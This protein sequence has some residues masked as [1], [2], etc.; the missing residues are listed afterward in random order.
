MTIHEVIDVLWQSTSM[1]SMAILIV[2]SLRPVV[3]R[4]FG[5]QAAYFL[6]ALVLL[7]AVACLLP[8]P[9]RTMAIMHSVSLAIPHSAVDPVA[10]PTQIAAAAVTNIQASFDPDWLI[11]SAWVTGVLA[12][13]LFLIRQQCRYLRNLGVLSAAEKGIWR[14]QNANAS[15]A[16]VGALRPRIVLPGAFE[17]Q[18]SVGERELIVAHERIHLRHG[19]P[20]INA[21]SATLRC[22]CWFNPLVHFAASRLRFD[23]ELACDAAVIMR[24][25]EARRTY[26]DAMLKVQ[27]AGESRQE[28][29]LPVGCYWPSGHPLKE[30]IMMLKQPVPPRGRRLTGVVLALMLNA[31]GSYLAWAAQPPT[32]SGNRPDQQQMIEVANLQLTIDGE[33]VFNGANGGGIVFPA[34]WPGTLGDGGETDH[35]I[36]VEFLAHPLADGRIELSTTIASDKGP[37]MP[38][39]LLAK[40]PSAITI[41]GQPMHVASS[42]EQSGHDIQL[43]AIVSVHPSDY[44]CEELVG[45]AAANKVFALTVMEPSSQEWSATAEAIKGNTLFLSADQPLHFYKG[46]GPSHYDVKIAVAQDGP[47]TFEVKS[48]LHHAGAVDARSTYFVS[49]DEPSQIKFAD[50]AGASAFELNYMLA[51]TKAEDKI[52]D[53]C[54]AVAEKFPVVRLGSSSGPSYSVVVRALIDVNGHVV[55]AMVANTLLKDAALIAAEQQALATVRSHQFVAPTAKN[56]IPRRAWILVSVPMKHTTNGFAVDLSG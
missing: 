13:L 56:G 42:K 40:L 33:I 2:L 27:L 28:L 20:Q 5:A 18:Y 45:E 34:D 51:N 19:D 30:R 39:Q 11:V 25:P 10:E 38:R 41:S 47:D 9:V 55:E 49:H 35:P 50:H 48:T 21:L 36:S 26:A 29:R 22:L 46:A 53:A 1:A 7:A 43:T 44:G 24:F 16:L 54:K 17:I 8:A 15:P 32:E 4:W 6:W 37:A 14:A 3:R 12:M 52:P 23:Q 31:V